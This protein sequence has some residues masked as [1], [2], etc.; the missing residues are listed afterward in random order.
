MREVLEA[1]GFTGFRR[2]A[3]TPANAVYGSYAGPLGPD[4]RTPGAA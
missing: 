4:R 3:D 2:I 1:A